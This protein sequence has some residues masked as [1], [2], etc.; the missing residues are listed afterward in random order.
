MAVPVIFRLTFK[1]A[2][3][4]RILIAALV[5]GVLFLLVYAIGYRLILNAMVEDNMPELI[6]S[7]FGSFLLMAGLYVVNF[8]TIIM[9]VLTAVDT[10]SGE[11][12]SGTIHTVLSKPLRRWEVVVGKW[13]GFAAMI[14]VYLLVMAGGVMVISSI[15]SGTTP[16]HPV[17]GFL[18]MW[19]NAMLMLSVTILGGSFLS[20]LANGVM[21]FGLY[22][23]SFIG[24]WIEQ[25]GSFF[26]D[27]A[28]T[29]AINIG[30]VTS[31][32]LPG[33]A[34]WR[35]AAS[36]LQSAFMSS[37][38]ASPFSANSIPSPLF[39][40]YAIGYLL[41][42]VLLAVRIISKRDL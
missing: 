39:I 29:A 40:I 37:F 11:M 38:A 17:R 41:L 15:L 35:R 3:R 2:S 18:L 1:E 36:E 13:L 31:L 33:E 22:G 26:R 16:P 6:Q 5:M 24:S 12:A 23:L 14:S 8:L 28:K 25:V 30:I 34:L 21:V 19:L 32:L 7:Q 9:T 27:P 10:L 4:R 20:T 42:A